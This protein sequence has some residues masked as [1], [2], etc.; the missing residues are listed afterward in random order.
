VPFA[1]ALELNV[2]MVICTVKLRIDDIAKGVAVDG[3]HNIAGA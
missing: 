2:E 3:K 1:I